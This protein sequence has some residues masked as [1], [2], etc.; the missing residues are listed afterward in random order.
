MRILIVTDG[1]PY[2]LTSGYLRHYNLIRALSHEHEITLFSAVDLTFREEHRRAMEPFTCQ[3]M[4]FVSKT[5]KSRSVH[6]RLLKALLTLVGRSQVITDMRTALTLLLA[7]QRFDVVLLA[8]EY[9]YHVV[10]GLATPPLI[11][12]MCD[13][14]SLR[15]RGRL[16]YARRVAR[17]GLWIKY[18]DLRRIE[19]RVIE[20]AELVM[21]AS[22]RDAAVVPELM[23]QKIV[24]LPNGVDIEYWRRGSSTLGL[25]TVI[26]TGAMHYPPNHD[27]SLY[28]IRE[29]LPYVRRAVPDVQLMIVGHSPSDQL[30]DA[31]KQAGAVVTGYVEDMRPYLEQATVFAAPLRFGSGIQNKILEALAME[32]PVVTTQVAAQ[33]IA[34]GHGHEPPI[35]VAESAEG[36]ADALIQELINRASDPAPHSAG[37]QF[38]AHNFVWE[39]SAKRL[40]AAI[41][42]IHAAAS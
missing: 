19:K 34:V 11:S 10:K 9:T 7:E 14:Y 26:F 4:T 5:T 22:E 8:G 39:T 33:G 30:I 12:D 32:L 35:A 40:A 42:Q 38:V 17:P 25:N 27:A 15:T 37:R 20:T 24:I 31:G 6:K 21:F 23:K 41:E 28:L 36:F 18:V 3:I 29:I 13:A 16:K 1:F 2:P